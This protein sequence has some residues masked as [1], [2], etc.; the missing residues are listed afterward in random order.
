MLTR[1]TIFILP[2]AAAT[3]PALKRIESPGKKKPSKM[4]VSTKTIAPMIM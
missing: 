4:P 3:R 1:M 2:C